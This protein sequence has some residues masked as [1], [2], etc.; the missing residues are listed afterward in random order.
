MR[1]ALPLVIWAA[2][3]FISNAAILPFLIALLR[4]SMLHRLRPL[5]H[6]Q[7]R[8]I[9][10]H[11]PLEHLVRE[12]M[13]VNVANTLLLRVFD[14]IVLRMLEKRHLLQVV[15]V[16]IL[17]GILIAFLVE[18]IAHG[19]LSGQLQEHVV[20][21]VL[22]CGLSE[23]LLDFGDAQDLLLEF[24]RGYADDL[25]FQRRAFHRDWLI[26][27]EALGHYERSLAK[28]FS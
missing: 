6:P 16:Q 13:E 17:I 28:H 4:R 27:F 7:L 23:A 22:G 26:G 5:L 19:L 3:R 11:R 2:L 24:D 20:D 9:D 18:E 12:V 8:T 14:Q 1:L 21:K 10:V 25:A 15:L